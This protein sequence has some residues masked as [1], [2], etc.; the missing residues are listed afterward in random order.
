VT[1]GDAGA[2]AK[3]KMEVALVRGAMT[4]AGKL[5]VSIDRGMVLAIIRSSTDLEDCAERL[6]D[7]LSTAARAQAVDL[8]GKVS[9]P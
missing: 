3:R 5:G 7:L 2:L 4:A 1:P 8:R 9:D 6:A